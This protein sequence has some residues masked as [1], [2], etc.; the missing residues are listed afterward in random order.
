MSDVNAWAS[1]WFTQVST[2]SAN[3]DTVVQ[4]DVIVKLKH[5]SVDKRADKAN[6][7]WKGSP[8][9]MGTHARLLHY[10]PG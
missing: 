5:D 7:L 3:K 6:L 4:R 10:G 1:H 9:Q 8:L 2:P